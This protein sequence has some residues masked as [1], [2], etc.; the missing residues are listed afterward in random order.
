MTSSPG[1]GAVFMT[2]PSELTLCEMP[3]LAMRKIG[4]PYSAAR[5]GATRAWSSCC[6]RP[7]ARNVHTGDDKSLRAETDQFVGDARVA[8]VVTDADADFTPR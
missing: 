4:T 5:V 7:Q 6:C 8:E 1:M 2:R 3:E